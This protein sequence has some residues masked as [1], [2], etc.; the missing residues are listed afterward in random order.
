MSRIAFFA[1]IPASRMIPIMLMMLSV[2]PVSH[3]ASITPISESGSDSMIASG[4]RNDPNCTTR[5]RYISPMA[6]PS[7][8][9]IRPN[10]SVWSSVSPP[11]VTE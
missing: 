11:K 2:E 4:S 9:M 1:T 3:S 8:S 5:I 7:A 6:M 10:T